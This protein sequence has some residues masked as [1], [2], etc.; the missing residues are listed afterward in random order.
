[1]TDTATIAK[2][3]K[4]DRNEILRAVELLAEPGSVVELRV[5]KTGWQNRKT[6]SGYYT[7]FGKLATD[8]AKYEAGT[9]YIT[10]NPTNKALLARR[11]N[12]IDEADTGGTTSDA[13]IECRR[14]LLIDCDPVK[15]SGISASD[16]EKQAACD[17]ADLI[18][19]ILTGNLGWAAPIICD[20][21]NG[22]HLLFRVDLPN[23]DES[24]KLIQ[25]VLVTLSDL[26]SDDAVSVD[27]TVYNAARIT[28]CYGTPGRK[29]DHTQDRPH[30]LSR[31][32][33]VPSD[34]QIVT[35]QQL[36]DLAGP[37]PEP[38]TT[39]KHNG[40]HRNGNGGFDLEQFIASYLEVKTHG[41]YANPNG[42]TYRWRLATCPLCGESDGSAV[43][44]RF[45]DGR[46]AYKCHHNRC[47]G[48]GWSALREHFEPNYR[49]R[50]QQPNHT[51]GK[52]KKGTPNLGEVKDSQ[53]R[54]RPLT[55]LGNAERIVD[56]YGD[57]LR[58]VEA[59]RQW[60]VWNG[61]R[62]AEDNTGEVHRLAQR[63]VRSIYNEARDAGDGDQAK[64][65]ARWASSSES[66][67]RLD[68]V[69]SL[70]TR[71]NPIAISL[72]SLDADPWLLNCDNGTIDLRTGQLRSAD[73]GDLITKTCGVEFPT[74][75]GID[76]PVWDEFLQTIFAGDVELIRFVQRL[77]GAALVGEQIEHVLTIFYG[78]GSNG[79]SVLVRAVLDAL[80]EYAMQGAPNL[81]M[82]SR[83]ERHLTELCDL[84][85]RR[86][87]IVS[88]TDDG[89]RINEAMVKSTTGGD[90]IRARRCF[91]DTFQFDPSHL[92]VLVTNH[93]PVVRDT[94]HGMWRR[95]RL[96][97]FV[98]TI[99]SDKQDK[100]LPDKLRREAPQILRWLVEGCMA[101]QR[102]GL[103]E[104]DS[105]LV[106]TKKY[107]DDSDAIK[108]WLDDRCTI[109][110]A[111]EC[112]ASVAFADY[113]AWCETTG[114]R[115]MKNRPFGERLNEE[116]TRTP[117]RKDGYFYQ[118]FTLSQTF[119]A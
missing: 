106:A 103:A 114:E 59:W 28:K 105:V 3:P 116:F 56:H 91:K 60:F 97:P 92:P 98:V 39:A 96:V 118:G 46:L 38:E 48:L 82:A 14:W 94:G 115:A 43:V 86:L 81:F 93:K 110:P 37:E 100:R 61:S 55:D 32:V 104:P 108:Q 79:K 30:R 63:V 78:S 50:Q 101:W 111:A 87:V 13:D 76:S 2:P 16:T 6:H 27:T 8:A 88:E 107:Q 23:D 26:H 1:M 113:K 72:E 112:K 20:S 35:A 89:A 95:L 57:R 117:R 85:G 73:P 42:A 12:R 19:E 31:I 65:V 24:T 64:A 83:G 68:A 67:S 66:K 52:G 70:A 29:G 49:D 119:T 51:N 22:R 45:G 99:P 10:L 62:W 15:P 75:P 84:H 36:V 53:S 33:R 9:A 77:T 21:G 25:R 109:D 4:S 11:A 74:E 90:P 69:V 18:T 34:L 7:D 80:G 54:N 58:Y 40:Y 47:A 41:T 71:Q 102:I 17:R 44:L 5:L